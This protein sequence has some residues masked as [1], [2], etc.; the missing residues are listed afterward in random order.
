MKKKAKID[1]AKRVSAVLISLTMI[2]SVTCLFASADEETPEL[3]PIPEEY[4]NVSDPEFYI[5]V[6]NGNKL[7]I[8]ILITGQSGTTFTNGWIAVVKTNGMDRG[9]KMRWSNL[10]SSTNTFSFTDSSVTLVS[11]GEYKVTLWIYD[12]KNGN[13][14]LIIKSRNTVCP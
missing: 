1:I 12:V 8:D 2:L 6:I 7:Y 10:S 9:E 11:G 4:Q 5:S 14:E 3:N 13:S